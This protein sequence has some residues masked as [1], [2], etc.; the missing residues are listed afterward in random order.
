MKDG[1]IVLVAFGTLTEARDTYAFFE[2]R[3]RKRF[4]D[5][6]ILWAF[7]SKNLRKQVAKEGISWKSPE[8]VL[9]T[10]KKEGYKSA[11]LQSLHIVPGIEFEKVTNAAKMSRLNVSVGMPLLSSEIDCYRTLDALSGSIS[12][13]DECIT[14]IVGHGSVH[15]GAGAVYMQFEEFVTSRYPK[16]VYVSMVEGLPSWEST[17]KKVKKTALRK[18]KFIPLMFVAGE[19]IMNDVLSNYKDSWK[20]QLEGFKIDGSEKGLGFNEKI[21]EIYF[22]HLK[23]A[24][25][26]L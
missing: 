5:K 4:P 21:L 2:E 22:D 19:H 18:I 12:D 17:R 8:R 25:E 24:M 3:L 9:K 13:P 26:K 16:N 11:V 7:S 10:L 23:D 20:T 15:S 14:V 1:A 6:D